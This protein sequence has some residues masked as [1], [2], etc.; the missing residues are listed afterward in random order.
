MNPRRADDILNDCADIYEQRRAV[1][2]ENFRRVGEVMQSLFPEGVKLQTVEDHNRFHILML[3]VVKLT[4]YVQNWDK[5]G[6]QDSAEDAAVYWAMLAQI[7][8]EGRA[9]DAGEPF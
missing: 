7:D 4:R 5:G 9:A 3:T 1:Y 2:G 6:H 8:E